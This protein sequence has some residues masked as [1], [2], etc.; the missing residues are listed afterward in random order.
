[1]RP[2]MLAMQRQ[3]QSNS[4]G[5]ESDLER[6]PENSFQGAS[7]D[8][9]TASAWNKCLNRFADFAQIQV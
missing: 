2:V 7:R 1:M 3:N 8:S 9:K 4:H 5:W 6:S